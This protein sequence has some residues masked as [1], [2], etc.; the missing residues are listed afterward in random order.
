MARIAIHAT[1]EWYDLYSKARTDDLYQFFDRYLKSIDNGWEKTPAVR[2]SVLHYN[3]PATLDMPFDHLPW[4][5]PFTPGAELQKLYLAHDGSMGLGNDD[6]HKTLKYEGV[7]LLEFAYTFQQS[8]TLVGPTKLVIHTACPSRSDFDIYAQVR[9]RDF[10]G[11]ELQHINMPLEALG[12][13]SADEV[14]HINP[15]MY[16][17]PNGQLRASKRKVAPELCQK[18]WDTLS[19]DAEEPVTPGEIVKMEVWIWPTAIHFDAGEQLVLKVSGHSMSLPEFEMLWEAPEQA[20]AQVV[21]VGGDY[22]S[23]LEGVWLNR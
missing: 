21:H 10:K 5:E 18:F 13:S 14:P 15:L 16:L 7:S 17:G 11:N 20:P 19:Q 4:H 6:T 3:K 8:T 22:G 12:V 9:K 2:L 1:Q 23:Y